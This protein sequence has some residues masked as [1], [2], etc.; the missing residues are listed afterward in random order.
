[1]VHFEHHHLNI[2]RTNIIPWPVPYPSAM[3]NVIHTYTTRAIKL[4]FDCFV[5]VVFGQNDTVYV[6]AIRCAIFWLTLQKNPSFW[7][8]VYGGSDTGVSM[9]Q[10]IIHCMERSNFSASINAK[11]KTNKQ[12]S[13]WAK[14]FL[15]VI[16]VWWLMDIALLYTPTFWKQKL[17]K[18]MRKFDENISSS[19]KKCIHSI[20]YISGHH[21]IRFYLRIDILVAHFWIVPGTHSVDSQH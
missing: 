18:S 13:K 19:Q 21:F 9:T 5:F 12:T 3:Y 15:F 2:T 14:S 11:W 8:V 7:G 20:V 16:S 4:L 1:M 10:W 17:W 6:F